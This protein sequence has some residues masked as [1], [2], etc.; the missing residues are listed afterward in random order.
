MEMNDSTGSGLRARTPPRS[1][2]VPVRLLRICLD[3]RV[4]GGVEFGE[5][6]TLADIRNSITEDEIAGVPPNYT[7]LFCGAPVSRRQEVRRKAADCFPFLPIIAEGEHVS[8]GPRSGPLSSEAFTAP[9]GHEERGAELSQDFAA[10]HAEPSLRLTLELQITE[11]PLEGTSLTVGGEGARIGRHT[12]NSLVIPE[13][14][15]SRYHCEI[16]C[17]GSEFCVRDLGSTT[18]T[19]FYLRPHSR[20]LM[21]TGLLIKLGETE[22]SVVSQTSPDDENPDLVVHFYEGPLS[23]HKVHVV[24]EGM[25]IGRRHSNVLV[26]L[27]DTT[28]SAHHAQ[29]SCENGEFFISD[30]GSCNGTCV[31]LS[32]ELI[33][34]DWHPVFNGDVLGAGCTK[35][36]CTLHE[37]ARM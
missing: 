9:V 35:V 7:F 11:G 3:D 13:P 21:F 10:P 37:L 15:I 33:Q 32:P 36:R 18:G 6:S 25:T 28:V 34:S 30:L 22:F 2:S 31:R 4:L 14:G 1:G 26:L 16:S 12:S 27:H 20:L 23:G 5:N 19:Y 24:S 17:N 8:T 29:I